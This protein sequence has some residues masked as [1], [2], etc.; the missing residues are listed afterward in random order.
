MPL[1][2]PHTAHGLDEGLVGVPLVPVAVLA[3]LEDVLA[4][5]VPRVLVAHPPAGD[6]GSAQQCPGGSS[7][8]PA[9]APHPQ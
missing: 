6:G 1:L 7:S 9:A 2:V 3:F 4:A 5:P 8:C